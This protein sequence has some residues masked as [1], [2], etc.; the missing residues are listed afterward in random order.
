M[1]DIIGGPKREVWNHVPWQ[2]GRTEEARGE[3]GAETEGEGT[4]SEVGEIY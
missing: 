1:R 3:R 2:G 4:L